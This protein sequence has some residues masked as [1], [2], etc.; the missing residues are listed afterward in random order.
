MMEKLVLV[1]KAM[2]KVFGDFVAK[3]V[4]DSV[5]VLKDAIKDADLD[6]KSYNQNLQTRLYQLIVDALNRFTYNK[7]EKQ[8][9]LYDASESIIKGYIKTQDNVGAVKSGLKILVSGVNNDTCQEFLETL[10][11]EIC[12]DDNSD[13][14]KEFDMLWKRQESEYFRGEFAKI[15]QNDREILEQLND[16]KEVLDFIKRNMNRQEG[17]KSGHNR[18]PIVNRAD[19]YAQR[20][21]KNVF[22]NNFNKRDR[23]SG[24]NIMLQEIYPET[25]LPHYRWKSDDEEF[26]DLKELLREY[27]VDN[28]DKKMLLILGQAGSGKSTLITWIMANLVEEKEN[29]LVYQFASD[30]RSVNWQDD[31]ILDEIFT[32]IDLGYNMLEGK[33][34]ILDG[35]DEI[36]VKE[37]RERILHK[38]NQELEKKNYL[39]KFSLVLTCREN[40]V[41]KIELK[42]IEYITLQ[43]WDEEQI[44]SFCEIYEKENTKKNS[45][46]VNKENLEKKINKIL[47]NKEVFG[48]PLILY[49]TL[50]LN[51]DVEKSRS[52]VDI[53]D[54]IFSLKKGGIYGR[55]YDVEH[56]INSPETKG[57]IHQV[58][59][60]I[61]FWMFE[62][63]SEE[64]SI[65]QKEFKKICDSVINEVGE[66]NDNLKSD[67]MIGNY[68][69]TVKHCDGIGTDELMFVHR[70]IYEYFVTVYFF[71]S[72]HKL[73]SKEE[74]AGKLGEFLKV[75]RLTKQMLKFIKH[76]FDS[77][78]GYSISDITKEVF[79]I[80][81]RDGMTY[82]V[83]EKYKNIIVR[84]MN[85]FSNML[86]VVLLW[87]F[88]LGKS[89]NNIILY[90]QN[91]LYMLNLSGIDLSRA[92]LRGADLREADL[93]D[94]YLSGTDLRGA[95]LSNADLRG[96]YLSRAC[97]RGVD[98]RGAYLSRADLSEVDLSRADLSGTDLSGSDL[99]G[100][101]LN[102]ADLLGA[103]FNQAQVDMLQKKYDLSES[104]VYLHEIDKVIS[105]Q[106]YCNRNQKG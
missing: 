42:G 38:L 81:L 93:N 91:N 77:L 22:L 28:D 95:Y 3:A 7:Y 26:T 82:Y 36:S 46:A 58:S 4:S 9:K 53:Y 47:E 89:N 10:C 79:N 59:Q 67:I 24:V 5:D 85:I 52:M 51:V 61:A 18:I 88:K 72:I 75:G 70:S 49:M 83:K 62:N 84:E 41:D 12:R 92:N 54:Q 15:D 101:Y 104:K 29:I 55:C 6:R 35:F 19:E 96:A 80:M 25:H 102:R 31:N 69:T 11:G 76:K 14:Y 78:K 45:E 99:R 105:Y 44:K 87:N 57:Y 43:A 66:R 98:L 100:A 86:E 37:N 48:I 64:V 33:T 21:N 1:Q 23:N 73:V 60:R 71:E 30:L 63:N 27:I 90:L 39:R 8:D 32:T 94:A 68:F 17:D 34:L 16:L 97:L 106:E 2:S 65:P 56:R 13:L 103:V 50:A 40:Y 74:I 20:W